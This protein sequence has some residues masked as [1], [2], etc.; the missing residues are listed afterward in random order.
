M[1]KEQLE[2]TT[3]DDRRRH[4]RIVLKAYAGNCTCGYQSNGSKRTARLVDISPGG[5]R[6]RADA[7]PPAP[8]QGQTLTMDPS[9]LDRTLLD[10]IP[11][12]T[13]R[14]VAEPEFGVAF[15]PELPL[16]VTELQRMVD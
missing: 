9:F 14:W 1:S 6:L 4:P 11:G 2:P 10:S 15:S 8:P 16:T 5:A 3:Q 13:V 7:D 12:C